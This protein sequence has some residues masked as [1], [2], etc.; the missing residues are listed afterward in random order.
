MPYARE[1]NEV[2]AL[3]A[4]T[5]SSRTP[6][7]RALAEFYQPNPVEMYNRAFRGLTANQDLSIADEA[8]FYALVNV[9]GA[10][11]FIHCWAEKEKWKFLA[12]DHRH[13][14]R[15]HRRQPQN[16]WRPH[17]GLYDPRHRPYPDHTSGYNCNT[18]A[19]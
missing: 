6:E 1:Y 2:K 16:R 11:T 4:K 15:R 17:V 7:Q 12:T 8:R 14:R 5:G 13:P 3:G 10:D 19:P 9:A 18:G